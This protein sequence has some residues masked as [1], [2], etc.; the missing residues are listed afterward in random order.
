MQLKHVTVFD[1][2]TLFLTTEQFLRTTAS[3]R[4][5]ESAIG[6]AL[7][8]SLHSLRQH[9]RGIQA[10]AF[11]RQTAFY[12]AHIVFGM[13][14][15]SVGLAFGRDRTT[16]RHACHLLEDKRDQPFHDFILSAL[17]W[18]INA[19]NQLTQNEMRAS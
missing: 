3:C 18:G 15:T 9:N 13:T 2:D 10:I 16:I 8:I 4:L 1:P 5:V 7:K 19:Q 17:Q 11:A 12:L 14:Y 6:S